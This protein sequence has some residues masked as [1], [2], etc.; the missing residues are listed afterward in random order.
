[1]N[2]LA[3]LVSQHIGPQAHTLYLLCPAL[4]ALIA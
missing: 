3:T 1:M 4:G 2:T